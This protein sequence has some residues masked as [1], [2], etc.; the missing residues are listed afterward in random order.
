MIILLAAIG[1][2]ILSS[3]IIT[4]RLNLTRSYRRT[5]ASEIASFG[6]VPAKRIRF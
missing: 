1:G 2:F 5:Q 3:A 4:V 6:L